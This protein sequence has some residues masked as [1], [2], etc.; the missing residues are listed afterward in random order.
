[1]RYL[2]ILILGGCGGRAK[3]EPPRM[4]PRDARCEYY[5]FFNIASTVS[6]VIVQAVAE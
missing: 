3:R 2:I 1:M 6:L 5:L 4:A